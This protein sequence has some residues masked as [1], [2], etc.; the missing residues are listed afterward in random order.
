MSSIYRIFFIHD[1]IN[2]FGKVS[3]EKIV[4]K[5]E[6][7]GRQVQRDIREMKMMGAPVEYSAEAAGYIYKKPW[8]I[9]DYADKK[10]LLF[11]LFASKIAENLAL[12]PVVSKKLLSEIENIYLKDYSEVMKR[13][14]YEMSDTE[15]FNAGII[16][17]IIESM[18]TKTALDIDYSNAYGVDSKRTVEPWHLLNYGGKWYVLAW[19]RESKELR[20][21]YVSRI[22][23]II[24]E[25]SQ[26]EPFEKEIDENLLQK[27]LNDGYGIFKHTGETTNI[28]VRFYEPVI[29]LVKNR[30]W[31]IKQ[32]IVEKKHQGKQCVELT[33][34]V[35]DYTE[36]TYHIL[37]FSPHAEAV[38]PEDFRIQWLERMK[39]TVKRFG[40][41]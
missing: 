3:T 33:I 28:V 34:P 40:E 32:K 9:F 25:F 31:H 27:C 6:I 13:I 8:S 22:S 39:E 7:T 26:P 23:K 30:K 2:R 5:F 4:E 21:F 36:I 29:N 14:S 17:R 11:Y 1:E 10:T 24:G 37:G 35:S 18:Q 19:C 41:L 38:S 12:L 15:P 20:T 16:T